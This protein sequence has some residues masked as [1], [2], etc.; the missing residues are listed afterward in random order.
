MQLAEEWGGYENSFYI[1]RRVGSERQLLAIMETIICLGETGEKRSQRFHISFFEGPCL[2]V[3]LHGKVDL[4]VNVQNRTAKAE[5]HKQLVLIHAM[6]WKPR[7]A[8]MPSSTSVH[9]H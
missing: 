1:L 4:K 9:T 8:F 2:F 5:K 3:P 6:D 7:H